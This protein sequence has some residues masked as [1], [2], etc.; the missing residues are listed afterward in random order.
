M[1]SKLIGIT[2][3]YTRGDRFIAY[4]VFG[5]SIVYSI[6]IIFLG[7]VIWNSFS[8]WPNHWWTVNFLI[9]SL[10]VP[11]IVGIVSTIW[12]LI[13]GIRDIRQL[14]IDLADRVED[15]N[16]NGQVFHEKE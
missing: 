9:T 13:G 1:F 16:D 10:I 14:F 5:Y 3:E 8:P 2:P 11:G 4:L 15:P 7:V 6:I 12:F